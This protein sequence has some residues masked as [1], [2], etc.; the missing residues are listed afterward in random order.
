MHPHVQLQK[1]KQTYVINRNRSL[2]FLFFF[3]FAVVVLHIFIQLIDFVVILVKSKAVLSKEP[4]GK[5]VV[6]HDLAQPCYNLVLC[7]LRTNQQ[8]FN[9]CAAP[10]LLLQRKDTNKGIHQIL[11]LLQVIVVDVDVGDEV[12]LRDKFFQ[13][14]LPVLLCANP[15]ADW[16]ARG[17]RGHSLCLLKERMTDSGSHVNPIE[18]VLLQHLLEQILSF[19]WNSLSI[20]VAHSELKLSDGLINLRAWLWFKGECANYQL[21]QQHPD[22]PDISPLA[23]LDIFV[24]QVSRDFLRAHEAHLVEVYRCHWFANL[25]TFMLLDRQFESLSNV[26]R[27]VFLNFAV[28]DYFLLFTKLALLAEVDEEY[29]WLIFGA[30]KRFIVR[31]TRYISLFNWIKELLRV[32]CQHKDVLRV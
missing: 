16:N 18:W 20:L 6:A 30:Q 23:L 31:L 3:S 7:Q 11:G 12:H 24:L 17:R 5:V 13:W 4:A 25:W 29:F 14:Y 8:V 21:V 10:Q 32:F 19:G 15:L 22:T 27:A 2:L 28:W 9:V 26:K 1:I